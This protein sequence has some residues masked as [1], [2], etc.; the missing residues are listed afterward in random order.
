[1]IASDTSELT[2]GQREQRIERADDNSPA[3]L[4]EERDRS[5]TGGVTGQSYQ[6]YQS[7]QRVTIL[8]AEDSEETDQSL[9]Y[10]QPYPPWTS[11]ADGL[12]YCTRMRI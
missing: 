4:T 7:H 10:D 11:Y 1:M 9:N 5:R 3:S 6:P 12:A 8:K 2:S